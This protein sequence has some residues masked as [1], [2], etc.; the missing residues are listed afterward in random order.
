MADDYVHQWDV[1]RQAWTD[2]VKNAFETK[3]LAWQPA[4]EHGQDWWLLKGE[5]PNCGHSM[6]QL[7]AGGPQIVPV[8]EPGGDVTGVAPME[9]PAITDSELKQLEIVCNCHGGH[10]SAD[11]T[12][13][14]CGYGKGM[15]I[16]VPFPKHLGEAVERDLKFPR[17]RPPKKRR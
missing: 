4:S 14:G 7:F 16:T 1:D 6:G 2:W 13:T 10:D 17:Q 12:I 9:Q 5:C 8:A 11:L 15:R 3:T